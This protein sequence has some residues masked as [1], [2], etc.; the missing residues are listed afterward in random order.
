LISDDIY[1]DIKFVS[2]SKG[3]QGGGFSYERWSAPETKVKPVANAGSDQ[4][5]YDEITLDG[6]LSTEFPNR[7]Q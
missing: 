4:I 1:I 6:S 3:T 5:V 2:W 7:I